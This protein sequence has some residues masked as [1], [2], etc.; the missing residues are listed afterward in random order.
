[1]RIHDIIG[2]RL[3][4]F[5]SVTE[6]AIPVIGL[7][8]NSSSTICRWLEGLRCFRWFAL[9]AMGC[10]I[11]ARWMHTNISHGEVL[12]YTWLNPIIIV[13]N[14]L[15]QYH[16][17]IFL[18]LTILAARGFRPLQD[19][20]SPTKITDSVIQ[21][22]WVFMALLILSGLTGI[23]EFPLVELAILA[24]CI[25]IIGNVENNGRFLVEAILFSAAAFIILTVV[26]YVFTVIKAQIFVVRAPLDNL[27]VDTEQ[28]L[29]GGVG[30]PVIA[31]SIG[32]VYPALL[33]WADDV[34]FGFFQHM[35]LVGSFL[36]LTK[37]RIVRLQ[38]VF[39]MALCYLIGGFTY[40]IVPGLGPAYAYPDLFAHLREIPLIT[41]DVQNHLMRNTAAAVAGK[42]P[43]IETYAYI[44][45]MPS[46]HMAHES[47]ML[48][49]S[50]GSSLFFAGAVAF[51]IFSYGATL[52]LGWHYFL[53]GFAGTALGIVAIFFSLRMTRGSQLE[54]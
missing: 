49:F 46:L 6:K 9:I 20:S 45:C 3:H 41:N 2:L 28:A 8:I 23:F 44:A 29:L 19:L 40:F 47:V 11:F 1:M 51:W 14:S 13:H 26:S 25:V 5:F 32:R 4:R 27:I 21:F 36:A 15:I 12:E 42:M 52:L 38:Y 7:K 17:P 48:F 16:F 18:L 10:L 24:F 33:S 22:S 37:P 31:S 54:K 35:F 39:A 43:F 34:Y 53:D 30:S 50:R